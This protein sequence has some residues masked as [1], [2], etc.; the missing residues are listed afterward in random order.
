V[1]GAFDPRTEIG[2]GK[3]V[4][5]MF[6]SIRSRVFVAAVLLIGALAASPAASLAANSGG[7]GP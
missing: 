5:T 2:R 7:G 6:W 1:T 4:T 3:E